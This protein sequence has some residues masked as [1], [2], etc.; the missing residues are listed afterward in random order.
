M[1]REPIGVL[2]ETRLRPALRMEPGVELFLQ[3]AEEPPRVVARRPGLRQVAAPRVVGH[4]ELAAAVGQL[5]LHAEDEARAAHG[6]GAVAVTEEEHRDPEGVF[7]R[8]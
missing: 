1:G 2:D 3:C 4:D 6:P 7:A 8:G 5:E